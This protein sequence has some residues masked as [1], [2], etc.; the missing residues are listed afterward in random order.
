MRGTAARRLA[1]EEASEA[2]WDRVSR[3]LAARRRLRSVP[4]GRETANGESPDYVVDEG[5]IRSVETCG[6]NRGFVR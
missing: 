6:L 2:K 3:L 5:R 4:A 1:G